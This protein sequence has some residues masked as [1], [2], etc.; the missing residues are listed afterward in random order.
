MSGVECIEAAQISD[1]AAFLI[2]ILLI[3]DD[4]AQASALEA[5]LRAAEVQD[6]VTIL[7]DAESAVQYLSALPPHQDR[8]IPRLVLLDLTLPVM[9]G[10]EL[11][12]WLRSYE[13]LAVS[14]V[15]VIVREDSLE[16][17]AAAYDSG[18]N[19]VFSRCDG[20]ELTLQMKTLDEFWRACEY[21]KSS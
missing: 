10:L 13:E 4:P 15:P 19:S 2:V 8:P 11:L 20:E 17:I 6:P 14:R 21:L 16:L 9:G 1:L 5:A 7:A 18:A 3:E 12:Y